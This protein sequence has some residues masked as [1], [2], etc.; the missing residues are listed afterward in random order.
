MDFL[1]EE[2]NNFFFFL[3]LLVDKKTIKWYH[4]NRYGVEESE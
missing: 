1:K 3:G 2:V 4:D